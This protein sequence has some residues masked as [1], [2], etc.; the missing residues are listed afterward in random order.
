MVYNPIW[1]D[2][3]YTSSTSPLVYQIRLDGTVIYSGKAVRR[4]GANDVR[5][6]INKI[7]NNYLESDIVDLYTGSS[8]YITHSNAVKTFDLVNSGGTT[9]EQYMFLLDYDYGDTWTG[10]EKV[11][12]VPINGHFVTGMMKPKTNVTAGN[13]VRTYKSTGDYTVQ[14][15]CDAKYVLY[16]LNARGGWDAFV[17]EGKVVKKDNITQYT[18]DRVFNNTTYDF[19]A[20]RYV[21]EIKTTYECSTGLLS[22]EESEKFGKHLISTNKA[23]LHNVSE[24]WMKPVIVDDK[25]VTYQ[26]YKNN[27]QKLSVYKVNIT[28]SQSRIR[29]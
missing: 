14:V 29:K 28:E 11:L 15:G 9:L 5:I 23:Y 17:F 8:T 12:S 2:T 16:Y 6:N 10:G 21:S 7:C 4:P 1:R 25:T 19:E 27:G 18:T 22:D 20:Y 13:A 3:Y 26:S 24:G